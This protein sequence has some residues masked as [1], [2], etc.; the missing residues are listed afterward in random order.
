MVENLL[1]S[2]EDIRVASLIPGSE[3]KNSQRQ[4]SRAGYSP[5]GCKE[6]DMTEVT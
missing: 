2:A 3:L 5:Q 6:S 1:A 4:K